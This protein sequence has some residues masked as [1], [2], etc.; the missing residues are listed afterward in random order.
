MQQKIKVQTLIVGQLQTNCYL[1]FDQKTKEAIIIDPGDDAQYIEN[2]L[3]DLNLVPKL[4]LA[5]H[6][7]FDHILVAWELQQAYQIPF[8]IQK[9][10]EFLVKRMNQSA[11][12]FLKHNSVQLPP[13]INQYLDTKKPI[14]FGNDKIKIFQ[15]PGHT[16][17]S[18][19][20]YY[21]HQNIL[22][23][24]DLIFAGGAVGRT[25]FDYSSGKD[26]MK[27]LKKILKLPS[28]TII[29]SGHGEVSSIASERKYYEI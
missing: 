10:D 29:Y 26:L 23:T 11:K 16:P 21:P 13:K 19:C 3:K 2:I 15:T 17:G 8:M 24:G 5:T 18:I 27:S 14:K 6:G 4:I 1:L 7:H 25:D 9:Y 12:Y 22:F 20:L 28:E